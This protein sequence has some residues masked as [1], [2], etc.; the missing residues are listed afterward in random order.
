MA[1]TLLTDTAVIPDSTADQ[2]TADP[3]SPVTGKPTLTPEPGDDAVPATPEDKTADPKIDDDAGDD[4]GKPEE[5]AT[6]ATEAP[7]KYEFDFPEGMEIDKASLDTATAVLKEMGAT[8]EQASKLVALQTGLIE[9]L[10][11]ARTEQVEA[12]AE[13]SRNH[14]EFGGDKFEA[15]TRGARVLLDKYGSDGLTTFLE[16]SG[17]GSNPHVIEFLNNIRGAFSEDNMTTATTGGGKPSASEA[18]TAAL[19]AM[20]PKSWEQMQGEGKG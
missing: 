15:T 20:Y 2:F 11:E 6:T 3:V 1:E 14:K 13:E 10:T 5:G 16:E 12:W 4:T 8:Q 18:E 7:E 17:G 9:R 19:K